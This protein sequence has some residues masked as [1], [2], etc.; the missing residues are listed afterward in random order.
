M[1]NETIKKHLLVIWAKRYTL[2]I[3]MLCLVG[4]AGWFILSSNSNK[5]SFNVLGTLDKNHVFRTYDFTSREVGALRTS[6]EWSNGGRLQLRVT[7]ESGKM[8]IEQRGESPLEVTLDA[9]TNT[10]YKLVVLGTKKDQEAQFTLRAAIIPLE[11][12][13]DSTPLNDNEE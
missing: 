10:T 11:I 2:P 5:N 3:I 9:R 4:M 7:N 8:L 12:N 13:T 6:V 1:E